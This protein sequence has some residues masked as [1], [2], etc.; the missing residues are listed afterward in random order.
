MKSSVNIGQQFGRNFRH[1]IGVR[2]VTQP[3]FAVPAVIK[4]EIIQEPRGLVCCHRYGT[5]APVPVPFV[6]SGQNLKAAT[7]EPQEPT[8]KRVPRLRS[9]L[10]P[11]EINPFTDLHSAH[12]TS[13]DTV[14]VVRRQTDNYAVIC[15]GRLPSFVCVASAVSPLGDSSRELN[16]Y[17]S[18]KHHRLLSVGSGS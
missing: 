6:L 5:P 8:P 1:G 18:Q 2:Q 3:A 4:T 7:R 9:S 12:A 17:S 13:V 11:L 15:H 14:L 16:I 10:A